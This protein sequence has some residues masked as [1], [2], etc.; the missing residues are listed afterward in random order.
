MKSSRAILLSATGMAAIF[1][2]AL[3]FHAAQAQ[4]TQS[5]PVA[6]VAPETEVIIVRGFRKSLR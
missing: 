4:A 2:S 6:E 3:P 1:F 5:V